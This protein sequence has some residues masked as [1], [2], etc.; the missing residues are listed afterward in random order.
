MTSQPSVARGL[1]AGSIAYTLLQEGGDFGDAVMLVYGDLV[2]RIASEMPSLD[3]SRCAAPPCPAISRAVVAT[4]E[5]TS[6][7]SGVI[8]VELLAA[9]M[10]ALR[11]LAELEGLPVAEV[12]AR[13]AAEK[14]E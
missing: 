3:Q 5:A 11:R 4:L 8:A 6:T 13:L 14:K 1:E 2:A 10:S 7:A 9:L 12:V